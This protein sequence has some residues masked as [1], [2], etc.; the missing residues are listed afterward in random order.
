MKQI[1]AHDTKIK[2][3]GHNDEKFV[4]RQET[5]LQNCA[6]ILVPEEQ[7]FMA[8][9]ELICQVNKTSVDIINAR[10]SLGIGN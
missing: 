4:V 2:E 6:Y 1:L 5:A 8:V 9:Q 3:Y 10:P 7:W